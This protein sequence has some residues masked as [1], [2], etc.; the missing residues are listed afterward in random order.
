M[1][2]AVLTSCAT[3]LANSISFPRITWHWQW[4]EFTGY[5]PFFTQLEPDVDLEPQQLDP[6]YRSN[7]ESRN[8]FTDLETNISKGYSALAINCL[9]TRTTQETIVLVFKRMRELL[10]RYKKSEQEEFLNYLAKQGLS[11]LIKELT[12]NRH[13][14]GQGYTNEEL[15]RTV[16]GQIVEQLKGTI[17]ERFDDEDWRS[18]K[19]RLDQALEKRVH[20]IFKCRAIPWLYPYDILAPVLVTNARMEKYIVDAAEEL[21]PRQENSVPQEALE[22]IC[23]A[24]L[25]MPL[26]SYGNP[27]QPQL[28][29]RSL[30]NILLQTRA[31]QNPN[32]KR[33]TKVIVAAL[34]KLDNTSSI[35]L[36]GKEAAYLSELPIGQLIAN[37]TLNDKFYKRFR[38]KVTWCWRLSF[39]L[40]ITFLVLSGLL[41][42][43]I[44]EALTRRNPPTPAIIPLWPIGVTCNMDV[45]F[46]GGGPAEGYFWN[47]TGA[48]TFNATVPG[49]LT[50][51][52][53]SP[54]VYFCNGNTPGTGT[55]NEPLSNS[56]LTSF[57]AYGQSALP[58]G[59]VTAV[60]TPIAS[61]ASFSPLEW[62]F[63]IPFPPAPP[64]QM[65]GFDRGL[66]NA[67]ITPFRNNPHSNLRGSDFT[68]E[69]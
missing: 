25:L 40:L 32:K 56:T 13:L 3:A 21:A 4:P 15:A 33:M 31:S 43:L 44:Y 46:M 20:E 53:K 1:F 41:A 60:I 23:F 22:A 10:S 19:T 34:E 24:L 8:A 5:N 45:A 38:E 47:I 55:C 67:S 64:S 52:Y 58:E 61:H 28:L 62:L 6:T 35:H 54:K 7:P 51:D 17:L 59:N 50:I 11:N 36:R 42:G 57:Y 68:K 9:N 39:L 63:S 18:H 26:D 66:T 12:E 48:C 49:T 14:T 29:R 27:L 65:P 2:D 16:L 37:T 30:Q 69:Q